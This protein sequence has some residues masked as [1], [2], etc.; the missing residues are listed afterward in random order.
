M[1]NYVF[2]MKGFIAVYRSSHYNYGFPP[3]LV[4]KRLWQLLKSLIL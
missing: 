1:M 2:K 3:A 4:G